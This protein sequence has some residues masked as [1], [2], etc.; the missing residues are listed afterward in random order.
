MLERLHV[1]RIEMAFMRSV[2]ALWSFVCESTCRES[3]SGLADD[4]EGTAQSRPLRMSVVPAAEVAGR[5]KS[6]ELFG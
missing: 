2:R 6:S 5:L 1:G 3:G 4:G